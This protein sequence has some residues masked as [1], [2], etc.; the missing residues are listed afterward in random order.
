MFDLISKADMN[1]MAEAKNPPTCAPREEQTQSLPTCDAGKKSDVK[2]EERL[3]TDHSKSELRDR[4]SEVSTDTDRKDH[5]G[6][7]LHETTSAPSGQTGKQFRGQLPT[8]S[9]GFDPFSSD[10]AKGQRYRRFRE[11]QT[12]GNPSELKSVLSIPSFIQ[13]FHSQ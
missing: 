5:H 4:G 7:K 8:S 13:S 12:Q 2:N 1:K 11:L 3:K 10:P 9:G 6:R